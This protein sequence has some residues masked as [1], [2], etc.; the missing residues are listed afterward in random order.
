MPENL[1]P[2]TAECCFQAELSFDEC[3][4]Y[5]NILNQNPESSHQHLHDDMKE[6]IVKNNTGFSDEVYRDASS[7]LANEVNPWAFQC[8]LRN[9]KNGIQTAKFLIFENLTSRFVNPC[10]MDLKLGVRQYGDDASEEK[11]LAQEMKCA[12]STSKELGLRMCGMQFYDSSS[13]TYQ[14]FDKYHGR[15]LDQTGLKKLVAK[16]LKTSAG[17]LRREICSRLLKM[18]ES[19]RKVISESDGLRLFGTSLLIVFEGSPNVENSNEIDVRLIDFAN[20]TFPGF[21][22][23]NSNAYSGP[24][25]GC[26]LGLDTL[27]RFVEEELLK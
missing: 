26:L 22:N 3:S 8:Q 9:F 17:Q 5:F 7:G 25:A 24:D 19:L 27:I 11:K 2:F 12:N 15:T 23:S 21:N 1:R 20:A 14:C 18:L 16:F 10:I 13:S 4:T 6:N